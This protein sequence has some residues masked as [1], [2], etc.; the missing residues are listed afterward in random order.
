MARFHR[1][2]PLRAHIASTLPAVLEESLELERPI[3]DRFWTKAFWC[4]VSIVLWASHSVMSDYTEVF[5]IAS[6]IFRKHVQIDR[7]IQP[8]DHIQNDLGL[9][10]LGVMEVVAD[11]EDR[12]NVEIPQEMLERMSTVEDVAKALVQVKQATSEPA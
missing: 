12:F 2:F 6:D 9:D 3:D 1:F 11:I 7:A 5:S 8:S 10:S 4:R